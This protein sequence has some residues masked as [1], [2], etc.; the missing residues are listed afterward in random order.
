MSNRFLLLIDSRINEGK[1][2]SDILL[3]RSNQ[4]KKWGLQSH[5]INSWMMILGEEFGEACKA[6][7]ECYFRDYPLKL[8]RKELIQTAAVSLAIIESIDALD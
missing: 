8:L 2:L 3:E 4:Q 5:G 6:G 1:A 7:N